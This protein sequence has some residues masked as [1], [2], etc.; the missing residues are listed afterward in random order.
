MSVSRPRNA[1]QFNSPEFLATKARLEE[2]IHPPAPIP[3]QGGD[4]EV[5]T[6]RMIRFVNVEDNVE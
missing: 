1:S 4:D 5:K 3:A 6:P 2:L